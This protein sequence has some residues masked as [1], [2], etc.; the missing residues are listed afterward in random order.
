MDLEDA[1]S[2][3]RYLIRDRDAK[4]PD[5]FDAILADAGIEILFSRVRMPRM[6]AIME[7]WGQTCRRE[8]LDRTLVWNQRHLLRVLREFEEHDNAH[9]PHQ[10]FANARPLHPLPAP[11]TDRGRIAVLDVWRRDRLGGVLCEYERAA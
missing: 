10:G 3:A 5:L 4:F 9:R 2:R 7:R 6:K 8:L 1:G 11:I